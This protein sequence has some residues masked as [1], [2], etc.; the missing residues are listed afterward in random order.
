[1]MWPRLALVLTA[2]TIVACGLVNTLAAAPTGQA[3]DDALEGLAG[4]DRARVLY[5]L[6]AATENE[7][8]RRALAW[9]QE[10]LAL[11]DNDPDPALEVGLRN[12]LAWTNTMLGQY[13]EA[14]TQAELARD[15]AETADLSLEKAEA[16]RSMCLIQ[17][18]RGYRA[19]DRALYAG[20]SQGR[21]RVVVATSDMWS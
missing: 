13:T 5:E 7:D 3:A 18:R 2:A 6:A 11:L 8:P 1:M 10:A 14:L 9:A 4:K 12:T 15:E 19:A 20:K 16:L 17:V 21:N